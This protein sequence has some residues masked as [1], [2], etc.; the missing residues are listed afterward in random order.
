MK[1]QVSNFALFALLAFI[2]VSCS[3]D[4]NETPSYIAPSTPTT[5]TFQKSG[6][7]V[8]NE[9]EFN[10]NN[11]KLDYYN[12]S[13]YELSTNIFETQ[14]KESKLILGDGAQDILVY[15]DKMYITVTNSNTIYITDLA[16]KVIKTHNLSNQAYK[17]P[18]SIAAHNAYIYIS[19]YSGHVIKIDSNTSE[20]SASIAID[21][22]PEQLTVANN[23]LY[24]TNSQY[25]GSPLP[26]NTVTVIDL[27]D[28]TKVKNK[29]EVVVNPT[30]ITSDTDGNLYVLSMGNYGDIKNTLSMIKKDTTKDEYTVQK[31]KEGEAGSAMTYANGRILLAYRTYVEN[32][33]KTIFSTFNTTNQEFEESFIKIPDGEKDR[34]NMAYSISVDPTTQAIYVTTT[35]YKTTGYVYIFDKTGNYKQHFKSGGINPSKVIFLSK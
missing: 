27:N 24:I 12:P 31:I 26:G 4:K 2:L 1:K 29:I 13:K 20:I 25:Y 3:D 15:E 14:N 10:G 28:F 23:E 34:L 7:F 16:G 33:N 32:A 9:G 8:L 18:R 6:A 5:P 22:Y 30:K 19:C 17:S 11:S 21:A 35:D